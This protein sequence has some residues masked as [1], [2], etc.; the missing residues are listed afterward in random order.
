MAGK[1]A[2]AARRWQPSPDYQ[3]PDIYA[4][5]TAR[6]V[7]ELEAGRVP[8]RRPWA[9]IA[10]D[11]E[12][13]NL[14]S[15]KPYR[16]WNFWSL[17][18]EAEQ[19]GYASSAWLTFKQALDKGG[20]VRKGEKGT[21]ILFWKASKY[22]AKDGE[23]GEETTRR[24]LLLRYYTVF[25]VAQC[26]GLELPTRAPRPEV[27]PLDAGEAILNGY[28]PRGPRIE[29]GGNVACYRPVADAVS[30]PR[31]EQFK[32]PAAFYATAFHELG[33]STGH[34]TRLDRDGIQNV[35]P[36]GSPTYSKE[37]LVAEFCSAFLLAVAGIPNELENSAAYLRGWL[38]ALQNDKRLLIHGAAQAHHAADY[39]LGRKAPGADAEGGE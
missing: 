25:N 24:G 16:G 36:F 11:G 18:L 35:A 29:Y 38:D 30:L 32:S 31:R 2:T 6:I 15:G 13:H 37:E 7:A 8:W 34:H 19:R 33:H 23:T 21:R 12:P 1:G 22:K 4:E 17:L 10:A 14:V 39:V 5:V 27:P 20:S 3:P 26:D 28:A 9:I